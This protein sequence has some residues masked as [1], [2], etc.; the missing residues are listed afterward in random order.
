M[1]LR[2][3]NA[4]FLAVAMLL[5]LQAR[6]QFDWPYTIQNGTIITQVPERPAG[7]QSALGLTVATPLVPD[8]L[9]S[10]RKSGKVPYGPVSYVAP[11]VI[12]VR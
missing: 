2:Y 5:P 12:S 3:I 6:A 9:D 8:A 10:P 4:L 7:Q 1:R 11:S